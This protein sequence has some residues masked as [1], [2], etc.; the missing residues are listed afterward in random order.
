MMPF[1]DAITL[2]SIAI[3]ALFFC[4]LLVLA[5]GDLLP[6]KGS[7]LVWAGFV[8]FIASMG[9]DAGIIFKQ[10]FE[11]KLW[12]T[13]W[14][15]DRDGIGAITVGVLQDPLGL[16]MGA[17]AALV[18]M[19][20]LMNQSAFSREARPEKVYAAMAIS[21]AGVALSWT[22]LTPWLSFV[23]LLATMLGG[24]VAL[25]S[26][27]ASQSEATLAARFIWE[28]SSGLLLALFGTCILASDRSALFLSQPETWTIPHA[29]L[30]STWMGSSLLVIGLFFQIQS[31]P[32]LG[33][34]VS[35][36]EISPPIRTLTHQIF[37][38]W[39]SFP[40]LIRLEPHFKNLGL[41]P[42]LG[43]V[44]LAACLLSIFCGLFQKHTRIGLGVWLNCGFCL[45]FSFLALS[46]PLTSLALL[47]GVSLSALCLSIVVSQDLSNSESEQALENN[48]L[49]K[50]RK[51]PL[52]AKTLTFLSTAAGSGVFGF[53]SAAGGIR[54][55]V[56]GL[57]TPGEIPLFFVTFLLFVLLRWKLT[58]DAMRN[59][60]L[61]DVPYL[62][63]VSLFLLWVLSLGI[64]WTG[65]LSGEIL[66]DRSDELIPSLFVHFFGHPAIAFSP[67]VD[68][69]YAC[70]LYWGALLLGFMT[71]Y[72]TSGRREDQWHLLKSAMPKATRFLAG[73]YQV[74][75]VIRQF[76]QGLVWVGNQTAYY[77]DHKIWQVWVPVSFSRGIRQVSKV[78]TLLDTRLSAGL[79]EMLRKW[80]EVP[81]KI[82]QLI[83]SGDLRWYLVFAL[84][85][86]F[87]LLSH[88]M[89][90]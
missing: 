69:I 89:R 57:S 35:D 77:V 10:D 64:V 76:G 30:I 83:Q 19:A 33:W 56:Q 32:L 48:D 16:S 67:S 88:F 12:K 44:G 58:W 36:S 7:W 63:L 2:L 62:S 55:V 73:G 47:I 81:A 4:G 22:S 54:W 71:A 80:I 52:I 66:P 40:I 87:A 5:L 86:G 34:S 14:I 60:R 59:R 23:G 79:N 65:T 49:V 61:W 27:W 15:G 29:E 41:F 53:V 13:G 28:R 9:V 8:I 84:G 43:W 50:D 72:W 46:G 70:G 82:L 20:L 17:L 42:V 85:S 11:V 1:E 37:P 75:Q 24:F 90:P 68:Y 21:A 25:G 74:D 6:G 51:R 31:F 39:A 45:S 3:L 38:F 78:F 26:R 18:S